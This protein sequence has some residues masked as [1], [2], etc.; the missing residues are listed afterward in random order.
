MLKVNRFFASSLRE[1]AE[2][3]T[4]FSKNGSRWYRR[5][6]VEVGMRLVL[7]ER[8]SVV[9]MRRSH[10]LYGKRSCPHQLGCTINQN[11]RFLKTR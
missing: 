4:A 9:L 11:Q 3:H 1:I 7:F 6:A 5:A 2:N 8:T 10:P